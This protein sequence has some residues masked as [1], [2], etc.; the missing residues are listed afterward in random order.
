MAVMLAGQYD[1]LKNTKEKGMKHIDINRVNKGCS[2]NSVPPV[3]KQSASQDGNQYILSLSVKAPVK[4]PAAKANH[5][6]G[7]VARK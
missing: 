6:T 7:F 4:L 3:N 1:S 5:P 2:I